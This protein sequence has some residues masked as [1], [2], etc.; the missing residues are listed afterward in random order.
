VIDPH[1]D[2]AVLAASAAVDPGDRGNAGQNV[3]FDAAVILQNVLL[4]GA[5]GLEING[6]GEHVFVDGR[7][8]GNVE[9]RRSWRDDR[10]VCCFGQVDDGEFAVCGSRPVI[11]LTNA[12]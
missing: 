3:A 2:F 5:R 8:W 9:W 7:G 10:V 12:G 1:F 4:P 6:R 11:A